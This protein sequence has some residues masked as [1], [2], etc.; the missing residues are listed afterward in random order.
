[1]TGERA[2]SGAQEGAAEVSSDGSAEDRAA[3]GARHSARHRP[4]MPRLST[5]LAVVVMMVVVVMVRGRRRRRRSVGLGVRR[6]GS[7]TG[8]YR[9]RPEGGCNLHFILFCLISQARKTSGATGM[10]LGCDGL[11]RNSSLRLSPHAP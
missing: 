9:K 2:S 7:E 1:V 11:S 6:S 8:D 5:A 10:F 4:I 3:G